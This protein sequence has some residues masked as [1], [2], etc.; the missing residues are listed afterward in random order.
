MFAADPKALVMDQAWSG[1]VL[2]P[3]KVWCGLRLPMWHPGSSAM[4]GWCLV[5]MVFILYEAFMTPSRR[6][7]RTPPL[8]AGSGVCVPRKHIL[9]SK[10][11]LNVKV[12][13]GFWVRFIY[14]WQ[15]IYF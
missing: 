13:G 1:Y 15:N 14:F 12:I 10:F 8:L 2:L 6:D 9:P 11:D 7:A 4:L 5:G 3:S